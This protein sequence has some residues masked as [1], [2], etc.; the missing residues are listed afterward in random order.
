MGTGRILPTSVSEIAGRLNQTAGFRSTRLP[1]TAFAV[2]CSA[3]DGVRMSLRKH[4]HG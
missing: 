2:E 4:L 1:T 3:A